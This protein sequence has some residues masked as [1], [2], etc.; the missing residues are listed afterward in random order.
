MRIK[1]W[2]RIRVAQKPGVHRSMLRFFGLHACGGV[3]EYDRLV[4]LWERRF[5]KSNVATAS[6]DRRDL[7][8]ENVDRP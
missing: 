7:S 2:V 8:I 1:R 3:E 5:W 6:R 4:R